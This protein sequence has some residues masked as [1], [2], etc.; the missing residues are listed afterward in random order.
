MTVR[1]TLT[2][3][4]LGLVLISS[5]QPLYS[6]GYQASYI[7]EYGS[8]YAP[9]TVYK[10][11]DGAGRVTYSTIWPEDTVAIEEVAMEPGP[12]EDSVQDTRRR[13]EKITEAVLAL[14]EARKKREADRAQEEKKRLER[15]ALQRSARPQVYERK[16]YVGWN[17]LWRWHPPV[18]HYRKYP[19]KYP[20]RPLRKPGLSRGV[21]LRTTSLR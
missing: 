19:D 9:E 12:A 10:S 7:T 14:T 18:A 21:P 11:V 20:S 8:G 3:S 16:V 1:L 2:A 5:V 15:L 6:S 4:M 13:H 17:P